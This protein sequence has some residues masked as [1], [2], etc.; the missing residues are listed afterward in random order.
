MHEFTPLIPTRH[1]DSVVERNI[2]TWESIYRHKYS[3]NNF[4]AMQT[5]L[6]KDYRWHGTMG[7]SYSFSVEKEKNALISFAQKTKKGI[8]DIRF[9]HHMFGEGNMLG[10]F[11]IIEGQH[12]G[13]YFEVPPTGNSIR[14]FGVAIARFDEQG[15]LVEERELWDELQL[16]RQI[17][18]VK[19]H[20]SIFMDGLFR[21]KQG[22]FIKPN[23]SP[24]IALSP[25]NFLYHDKGSGILSRTPQ[26][27]R[28]IEQ[29]RKFTEKKYFTP[30][31]AGVDEV[32]HAAYQYFG[33]GGAHSDMNDPAQRAAMFEDFSNGAKVIA[34]LQFYSHL[35]GEGDML[36]YNV[37]YNY[38]H[39]GAEHGYPMNG[40]PVCNGNISIGR[41]DNEGKII[42]EFEMHDHLAHFK[43]LGFI[44]NTSDNLLLIDVLRN[45]R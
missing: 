18:S 1:R 27:A 16:L 21:D 38:R 20:D 9:S 2:T 4:Q 41:F 45:I 34:D 12:M 26:V 13:E 36:A 23:Y 7:A 5:L 31:F 8:P 28:N 32:M 24:V 40:Q 10:N 19:N 42:A 11:M 43:Q 44:E 22:E 15:K 14:F 35:F 33:S 25:E 29:W 3:E 37:A 39:M 30:E 17:G 6:A